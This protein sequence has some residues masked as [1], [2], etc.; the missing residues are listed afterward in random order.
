MERTSNIFLTITL[1]V[2]L[3]FFFVAVTSITVG[4]VGSTSNPVSGMTITTLLVSCLIFLAIGWTE[5]I[6]LISALTMAVVVNIA[7]ALAG[8][9]S[10]DLKT[11][12]LVGATPKY[13]QIAEIIGAIIPAVTITVGSIQEYLV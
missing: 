2:V 8:T 3:G 9:T 11:G 10:Q 12:F 13:Q 4:L 6:Y 7:V 5:K 1:L